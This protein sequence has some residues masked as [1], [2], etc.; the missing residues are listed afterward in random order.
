[1]QMPDIPGQFMRHHAGLAEAAPAVAR[2]V[3]EEITQENRQQPQQARS[4]QGR[5]QAARHASRLVMQIFRQVAH[6]RGDLMVHQMLR[7][8]GRMAQRPDFESQAALLQSQQFL[9]DEGLR[10]ARITLHR[11]RDARRRASRHRRPISMKRV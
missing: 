4:Q 8:V 5:E 6:R 1:M 11:D 9:R 7:G 2:P 3:A 10:Q